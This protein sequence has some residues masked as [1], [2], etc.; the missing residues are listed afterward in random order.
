M[1]AVVIRTMGEFERVSLPEFKDVQKACGGLVV[2]APGEFAHIDGQIVESPSILAE[3]F[4]HLTMWCNEEAQ[5][6][7][8]LPN[9]KA[10]IL[11][12]WWGREYPD[13]T[14]AMLYG[15][16][17]I[18]GPTSPAGSR[19][20]LSEEDAAALERKAANIVILRHP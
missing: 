15:D 16:V 13:G 11:V 6:L 1:N 2:L 7:G 20:G 3:E 14:P 4:A 5:L 18:D 10:T 17:V 19:T 8:M 12:G 9:H